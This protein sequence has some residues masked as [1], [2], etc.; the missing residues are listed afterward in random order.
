MRE[1]D[2]TKA[3]LKKFNLETHY[4]KLKT[5]EIKLML[6]LKNLSQISIIQKSLNVY[7]SWT[8]INNLLGR[9]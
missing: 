2:L 3:M 5:I 1:R 6:K 8:L 7:K 9:N 4:K